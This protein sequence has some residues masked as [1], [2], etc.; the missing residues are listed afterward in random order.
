MRIWDL[1]WTV[2]LL[3]LLCCGGVP[4]QDHLSREGSSVVSH[5]VLTCSCRLRKSETGVWVASVHLRNE[6]A[7]PISLGQL[8]TRNDREQLCQVF[9]V[10]DAQVRRPK[11]PIQDVWPYAKQLIVFDLEEPPPLLIPPLGSAAIRS[12]EVQWPA[13]AREVVVWAQVFLPDQSS[14]IRH[15]RGARGP[16]LRSNAFL[17]QPGASSS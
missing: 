14:A 16:V 4:N 6:S 5:P 11:T 10:A 17:L 8:R 13:D 1:L 9:V 7:K 3:P 12:T 15:K 2:C